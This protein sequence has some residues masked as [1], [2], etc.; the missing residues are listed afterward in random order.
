MKTIIVTRLNLPINDP[1]R[2]FELPQEE[3]D[4][5]ILNKEI[6]MS[7]LEI[8]DPEEIPGYDANEPVL[9]FEK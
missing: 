1:N 6:K 7:E 3:G 4:E 5:T 2:V 8:T 9:A